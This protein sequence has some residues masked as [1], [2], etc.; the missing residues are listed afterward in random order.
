MAQTLLIQA[1]IRGSAALEA[2]CP[3]TLERTVLGMGS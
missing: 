3:T 2:A 1:T